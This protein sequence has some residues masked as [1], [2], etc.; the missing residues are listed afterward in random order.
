MNTGMY[1][2]MIHIHTFEPEESPKKEH[3]PSIDTKQ[4]HTCV[5]HCCMLQR[6]KK[7]RNT[8]RWWPMAASPRRSRGAGSVPVM[9][10]KSVRDTIPHGS[11]VVPIHR[12]LVQHHVPDRGQPRRRGP[13]PRIPPTRRRH[14]SVECCIGDSFRSCKPRQPSCPTRTVS[15][16]TLPVIYFTWGVCVCWVLYKA[17]NCETSNPR[18]KTW[19]SHIHPA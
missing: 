15:Y 17:A 2:Y 1:K 3:K 11:H 5:T 16:L 14:G 8:T 7:Q 13:C 4:Q 19:A 18:T 12:A 6:T 10:S 9:G